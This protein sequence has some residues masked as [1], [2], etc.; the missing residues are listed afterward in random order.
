MR[1]TIVILLF[2]VALLAHSQTEKKDSTDSRQLNEVVV[3]AQLQRNAAQ[4]SVYFP[5]SKQRNASQSGVDLI[6]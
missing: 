2:S 1:G 5:T 4:K 3:E 6:D